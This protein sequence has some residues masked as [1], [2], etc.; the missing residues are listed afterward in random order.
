MTDDPNTTR[1]DAIAAV[2]EDDTQINN[3]PPNAPEPPLQ[4]V[5]G[6]EAVREEFEK[7]GLLARDF[8][9]VEPEIGKYNVRG[10]V[11]GDIRTVKDI[12]AEVMELT[13]RSREEARQQAIDQADGDSEMAEVLMRNA[14]GEM[15]IVSALLGETFDEVMSFAGDLIEEDMPLDELPLDALP[16]ILETVVERDDL[17][18]TVARFL[19]LRQV[20]SK[21]F[22][23][24]SASAT[25]APK[26]T[27]KRSR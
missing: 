12:V 9:G 3:S 6:E 15:G 16:S 24:T 2:G 1:E 13:N 25:D 27:S 11:V 22:T 20:F 7:A 26:K 21:S 19:R 5:D 23:T 8:M 10:L 4:P 18:R 14:G 17:P